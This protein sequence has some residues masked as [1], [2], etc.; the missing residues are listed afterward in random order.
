MPVASHFD[1]TPHQIDIS[2]HSVVG[3]R[4]GVSPFVCNADVRPGFFCTEKT[5]RTKV[6]HKAE[7]N[8]G[9]PIR[10]DREPKTAFRIDIRPDSALQYSG[11]SV[12]LCGSPAFSV[13]KMKTE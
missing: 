7:S 6:G 3:S 13:I 8:N 4:F 10:C 9:V 5:V 12:A 1:A 11:I 2:G